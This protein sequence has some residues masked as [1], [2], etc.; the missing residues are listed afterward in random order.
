[1]TRNTP[2]NTTNYI[3]TEQNRRMTLQQ[4]LL[5]YYLR[6]VLQH[7][8][9]LIRMNGYHDFAIK[10]VMLVY[11]TTA[12]NSDVGGMIIMILPS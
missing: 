1:M 7:P 6:H 12:T 2:A 11:T 9:T 4:K 5:C 8:Q 3:S 10:E